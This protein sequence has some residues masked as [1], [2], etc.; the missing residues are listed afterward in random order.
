MPSSSRTQTPID[1]DKER[2]ASKLRLLDV[3]SSL[4]AR[5]TRSLDEDDIVDLR[6][7]KISKDNGVLRSAGKLTFGSMSALPANITA[8]DADDSSHEGD[9]DGEEEND[10]YGV[11]ELDAF[12]ESPTSE[13][14]FE[15]QNKG[16]YDDDADNAEPVL[17]KLPTMPPLGPMDAD[18]LNE[19]LEAERQRKELCGT[20]TE[21]DEDYDINASFSEDE[22][23]V[24]ESGLHGA[25]VEDEK[26][27]FSPGAEDDEETA[28]QQEENELNS[29]KF[30]EGVGQRFTVT[31]EDELD[32]WTVNA[33]SA[34]HAV[35]KKEEQTKQQPTVEDDSDSDIEFIEIP[36]LK[37]EATPARRGHSQSPRKKVDEKTMPPPPPRASLK[38]AHQL[39]TPP[40]SQ[41]SSRPSET[42][43]QD[44]PPGLE[45][46]SLYTELESPSKKVNDLNHLRNTLV[47]ED[48]PPIPFVDFSHLSK[49][50]VKRTE[51]KASVSPQKLENFDRSPSKYARRATP[52]VLLTPRRGSSQKPSTS[53]DDDH[54]IAD[55][56]KT[57]IVKKDAKGKG[58]AK[59]VLKSSSKGKETN[60]HSEEDP[61]KVQPV[62]KAKAKKQRH[63]LSDA[64][65]DDQ[66]SAAA[67]SSSRRAF[68][69]ISNKEEVDESYAMPAHHSRKSFAKKST[70]QNNIP[71]SSSRGI[72]PSAV[73]SSFTTRKRKRQSSEVS[74]VH[75]D[76]PIQQK[77]SGKTSSPK[78]A[79][80]PNHASTSRRHI[81]KF[82]IRY[83]LVYFL[84]WS[85]E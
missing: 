62:S 57:D 38:T 82:S 8:P 18:D 80:S 59:A 55:T 74:S 32:D 58:K 51:R 23:F 69:R 68:P 13:Q 16:V 47:K 64:D 56:T 12:V 83:N 43:V 30:L 29:D 2:E 85:T 24:F 70:S 84:I 34:I 26:H 3:W 50:P 52:I 21:D 9:D 61:G 60:Y 37:A 15:V 36:V 33:S 41:S 14:I 72:S 28:E 27:H 11:D 19:F 10:V 49:S 53:F 7:M 63:L 76:E 67:S 45:A 1:V 6:T 4:A 77:K 25:Q 20:D 46:K 81:G 35:I 22:E 71:S 5:Y 48:P 75:S 73:D 42:P 17:P 65:S 54:S 78:K 39:H 79:H 66:A 44:K 31:S 40:L